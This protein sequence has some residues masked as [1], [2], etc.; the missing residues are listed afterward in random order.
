MDYAAYSLVT[1]LTD[2]FQVLDM[3]RDRDI[4][5]LFISVD[6][7]NLTFQVPSIRNC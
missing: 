4:P 6:V 2:L 7:C 5:H 3:Y 1:V